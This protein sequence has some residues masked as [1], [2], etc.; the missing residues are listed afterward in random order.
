[1]LRNII[2]VA[3]LFCAVFPARAQEHSVAEIPFADPQVVS[4]FAV[5]F[6]YDVRIDSASLGML[7]RLALIE[8]IIIVVD[9]QLTQI[10]SIRISLRAGQQPLAMLVATED[11]GGEKFRAG[12]IWT[13]MPDI[14]TGVMDDELMMHLHSPADIDGHI[15]VFIIWRRLY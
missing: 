8:K 2:L 9:T 11:G 3:L 15:R 13:S 14:T 6:S 1:M 5:N 4:S 12:T 10:D 7:P